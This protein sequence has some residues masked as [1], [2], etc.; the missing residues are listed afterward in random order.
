MS[1]CQRNSLQSFRKFKWGFNF[2][3]WREMI[4]CGHSW[5]KK[6][7]KK[8]RK[9]KKKKKKNSKETATHLSPSFSLSFSLF[10]SPSPPPPSRPPGLQGWLGVKNQLSPCLPPPLFLCEFVSVVRVTAAVAQ[11]PSVYFASARKLAKLEEMCSQ[12]RGNPVM[13]VNA[14][15]QSYKDLF[16]WKSSS[17]WKR[18]KSWS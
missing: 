14:C 7:Q 2:A 1:A 15:N 17:E 9:K 11:T 4:V 10:L 16:T 5:M 8:E 3:L 13:Q 12:W 6:I 18:Q